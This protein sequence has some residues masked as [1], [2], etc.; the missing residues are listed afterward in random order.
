[1]D[2]TERKK[3]I[4][5]VTILGA[6]VN[7][8]LAGG[9]LAAGILGRSSAMVAD[10]IHSLSDLAT[11]FVVLT[12][13]GISTK[14]EDEKHH[15]GHGKFETLSTIIVSLA[16]WAVGGSI[17]WNGVG[18]IRNI[19]AGEEVPRPGLIAFVAATVSIAVKEL[20]YQYTALAG[21][22]INS[23]S[24]IANAWHHRSDALSSI[25]TLLGIGLAYFMGDEWRIAD[26]IAAILVCFFIFR[27]AYKMAREGIDELL[28][29]ALP[30][31]KQQQI[32]KII[33]SSPEVSAPHHLRTRRIGSV[34]AIE[35][36]IRVNGEMTVCHSHALA[37]DIERQL[38]K[39]FG[40]NAL[41]T[42]HIEPKQ[43][44]E[45]PNPRTFDA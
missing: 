11:D 12:F 13:V 22:K 7:V 17:L 27:I 14:P 16:L 23:P 8:L 5:H 29:R 24:V 33:T 38:K 15:Y 28:E 26:P 21:R 18:E 4:Y 6:V 44:N 45:T 19:M 20:L 36:H 1:M 43:E 32:L 2:R 3:Q 34:V 31:E 39:E 40:D 9:K 42:I 30:P 35:T 25:G 10:A 37:T 41:I